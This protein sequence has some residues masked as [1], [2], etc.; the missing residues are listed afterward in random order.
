MRIKMNKFLRLNVIIGLYLAFLVPL[1]AQ[2]DVTNSIV[3]IYTVYN[4]HSYFRP[5]QM[6]GQRSI[7]GSGCIIEG[8]RV[9][10]NAHVVADAT[11]IQVKRAGQAKKFTAEVDVVAHECDLA[12]LK[13]KDP[14]FFAGAAALEIG[15]LP[16]VRDKV[17]TYGFPEGGEELGITEGVVS[18]V[19]LQE[20]THS[21]AQLLSCQIDAAINP[22]SSGGPVIKGNK[23]VGVAFQAAT[24]GENIGYMVPAS[25]IRHFLEDIKDG[26]YDG[27]P[28]MGISFQGVENPDMRIMYKMKE[29]YSGV[30]V[31]KIY[32]GSPA[33][34]VL[35]SGDVILAV[36]GLEVANNGTINF[37]NNERTSF[38]YAVQRKYIGETADFKILRDGHAMDAKI[39]LTIPVNAWVLVPHMQYDLEPTYCIVGG[40]VFMPLTRNYLDVRLMDQEY[41]SANLYN[42]LPYY[43]DGEP[44]EDRREVVVLTTVLAD[45]LNIGYQDLE[46]VVITVVNGVAI[47]TIKDLVKAVEANKGEFHVFVDKKGNRIVLDRKHTEERHGLIL[48]KYKVVSDRS[49]DLGGI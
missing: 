26:R 38:A 35:E 2:E 11:F 23:V 3:K 12:V 28:G 8:K 21:N 36:D 25:V 15:D 30:L 27:I 45:E 40:L 7:T 44:T 37:R 5:W 39:K 22:G 34:G 29:E 43:D 20:Y 32:P 49:E 24:Q 31:N 16:A 13:V 47:S 4:K 48:K 1:M 6:E 18:R 14:S 9:L 33:K 10:T 41:H 46:D 17:A 42:L 19:E